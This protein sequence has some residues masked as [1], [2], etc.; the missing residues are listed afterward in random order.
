MGDTSQGLAVCLF[1]ALA[2]LELTPDRQGLLCSR[3]PVSCL[4]CGGLAD[5]SHVM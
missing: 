1:A 5:I 3:P 4:P 2:G